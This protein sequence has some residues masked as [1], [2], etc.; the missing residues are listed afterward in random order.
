MFI[1]KIPFLV[2]ISRRLKF[3]RIY[4]LSS[5]NEISLVTSINKIVSYYR[6]HGLHV[7]KM[8]V[9]PDFMSLE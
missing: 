6:S 3:A 8:S 4:Y 2:R 1:S 5:K 7:D 9:E